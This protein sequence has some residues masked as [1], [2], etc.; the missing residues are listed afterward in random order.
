MTFWM[1]CY[2]L[3]GLVPWLTYR[4]N[5]NILENLSEL[6]TST[7][8][9]EPPQLK[10]KNDKRTVMAW[11]K[12]GFCLLSFDKAAGLMDPLKPM[13]RAHSDMHVAGQC[14]FR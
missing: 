11:T 13:Q 2:A 1:N 3:C 10:T 9:L 5:K 4:I 8:F 12:L 14:P 7:M 6:V